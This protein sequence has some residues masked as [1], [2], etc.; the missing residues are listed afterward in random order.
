MENCILVFSVYK[1]RI[2]DSS[3]L[4][5]NKLCFHYVLYNVPSDPQSGPVTEICESF[6]LFFTSYLQ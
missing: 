1:M 2:E 6:P 4:N 5:K 3:V